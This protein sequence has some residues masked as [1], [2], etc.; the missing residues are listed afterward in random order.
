MVQE[1]EIEY[2]TLLTKQEFNTLL[3]ALSFPQDSVSQTNYY[4]DTIDF[5]LKGHQSALRIRKKAGRYTLTLKEPHVE[6]V[7]ETHDQLSSNEF[8]Q[9]INGQPI[10]KDNVT[11]QLTAMG[12]IVP[13]LLFYG[14]LHTERRTFTE[15]EIIYVI[16][17]SSYNNITDYELEIE[18]PSKIKGKE[19]LRKILDKFPVVEQKS[20]TKIERFFTTLP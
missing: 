17:K 16:D 11:H 8:E 10:Q 18:A 12:V 5:A 1:I 15:E 20:I 2:K 6:G 14:A 3:H 19:A 4:F 13:Q 9:W 7:L